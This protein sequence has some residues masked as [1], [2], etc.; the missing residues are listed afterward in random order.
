MS[1]IRAW[2]AQSVGGPLEPYE[3]DPG[4]LGDEDVEVAIE[5]CGLCHSDLSVLDNEW[6]VSA[7]PFV[8]GHEAIGRIVALGSHTKGLAIG[9]RV[10]IGWSCESCMHCRSCLAGDLHLCPRLQ[11]TILGHFGGFAERMR[12]AWPWVVPLPPTVDRT[13]A[14]PLL[15]G[16]ITVFAPLLRFGIQ[17]THRVGV[18]GIGGLGHM[19]LAFLNAWGCE[20]TAFTSSPLKVDSAK[21]LGAHKVVPTRDASA[22]KAMAGRLDCIISTVNVPLDWTAL[23]ST[24]GP[25]GRLH[26][27]GAVLEPIP[28]SAMDLIMAERSVSGSPTGSRSDLDT[29]LEFAGRHNI[30]PQVEHFPMSKANQAMA[31]LRAGKARYRVVLDADFA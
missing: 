19:A 15:C 28:V 21:K 4:P 16:G 23:I 6:G 24:L 25:K 10:G 22:I 31:H 2:A 9:Q 3:Y 26:V 12:A 11:P 13:A 7:Y 8:P 14:G 29:M 1:R 27:V 5:H 20:V 30:A 17:P 18:V